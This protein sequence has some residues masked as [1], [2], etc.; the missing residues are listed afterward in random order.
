[1]KFRFDVSFQMSRLP[2]QVYSYHPANY[3]YYEDVDD[4]YVGDYSESD[5]VSENPPHLVA[6]T[7]DITE[8]YRRK[9]AAVQPQQERYRQQQHQP[10]FYAHE[11]VKTLEFTC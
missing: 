4:S 6:G 1:M 5:G 9:M 7:P 10:Y 8:L 11:Y 3:S 2:Q